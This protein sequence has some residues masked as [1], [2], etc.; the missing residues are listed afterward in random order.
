MQ[1]TDNFNLIMVEG[2]DTVNL[3]TQMN[4][5]TETIDEQ[6]FKNQNAGVQTATELLSGTVHAILRSVPDASMIRFTAVS[7]FTAGDTFTVDGVQVS[8]LLP[9]GE[10]LP[11]GAFIIGSEV[12][13]ILKGTLLTVFVSGGSVANAKDSEKLG[14]ELPSY[15]ATKA[16]VDN[17]KTVATSAGNVAEANKLALDNGNIM[18]TVM[19]GVPMWKERGADAFHPFSNNKAD[20]LWT[21]P[22][23]ATA[24]GPQTVE[25]DL[26]NYD[27]VLIQSNWKGET[28]Y[29]RYIPH[30]D[31]YSMVMKGTFGRLLGINES[32][33]NGPY[34]PTSRKATVENNGVTFG[35]GISTSDSYNDACCVPCYIWGIKIR[36]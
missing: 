29:N 8:A 19:E 10:Q 25:L 36:F 30:A 12:L 14:G 26:T 31:T 33:A 7:R 1:R 24:F 16:E 21:N 35:N 34:S 22:N 20:L 13:C 3:L 5:N 17:A 15:Y 28:N 4:P 2:S 18:F 9:S 23:P 32:M 6:M 11:D 27:A